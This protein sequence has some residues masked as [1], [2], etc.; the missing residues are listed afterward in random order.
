MYTHT[1]H[2]TCIS[3]EH[4]SNVWPEVARITTPSCVP[5]MIYTYIYVHTQAVS[6]GYQKV[7]AL[8]VCVRVQIMIEHT[9]MYTHTHIIISPGYQKNMKAMCGQKW[10]E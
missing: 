2:L 10:R 5:I 4:E 9:Y 7:T 3:E 1:H 8:C 6:P